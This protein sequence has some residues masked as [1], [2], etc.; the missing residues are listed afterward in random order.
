MIGR[1]KKIW[2]VVVNGDGQTFSITEITFGEAYELSYKK[3]EIYSI[4]SNRIRPGNVI[5]V[6]AHNVLSV[7][8]IVWSFIRGDIFYSGYL[9]VGDSYV[10][11][12]N[13]C[14]LSRYFLALEE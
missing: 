9:K 6:L 12:N 8:P 14:D 4:G 7:T 11:Y 10:Y 3:I 2:K 5:I 13:V 1:R